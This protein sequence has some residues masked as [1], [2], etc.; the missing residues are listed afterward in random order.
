MNGRQV[1]ASAMWIPHSEVVLIKKVLK[2]IS[3]ILIL[4]TLY[5]Q[6]RQAFVSA[7]V[8]L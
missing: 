4:K 7:L 5:P 3:F 6:G 1:M 2:K 8:K